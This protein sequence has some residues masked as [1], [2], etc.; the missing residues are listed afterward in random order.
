MSFYD[1]IQKYDW[2]QVEATI[3]NKTA[4]DVQRALAKSSCDLDDFMALISPAAAP[5]IE[6]MARKSSLL[7]QQRFGNTIQLYI[8]L[9]VSNACTNACVYCG[10]NHGNDIER[11][12]L[13]MEE[14]DQEVKRLKQFGFDHLLLVSG[15]DSRVCGVDY[16][17]QAIAQCKQDFAQLS[18]EVQPLTTEEYVT[19]QQAGLHAVYVYQ[20]TYRESTYKDYHPRGKKSNYKYRLETPDRIGQAGI[21]KIGLGVL[22]GL[23]DWR[24]DS[25]FTAL[26]LSYLEKHYWQSKYS[27]SFPRL[28]PFTGGFEPNSIV[29]HQELLQ[30]MCAYRLL[31]EHLEISLSTRESAFFRDHV[32][33]L[34]VTTMSAG[35]ST[36]PGGYTHP[37]ESLEQFSVNDERPPKVVAE[38]VAQQGYEVVWKDWEGYM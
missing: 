33:K 26:H 37:D 36:S 28:R 38:V 34:G 9:Y 2:D 10:F 21:H 19:L 12:V 7:T 4:V 14:L 22:L 1:V 24:T 31:N 29:G 11:K 32:M 5:Y 20:E 35:S 30:L 18:I 25:F 17:R 13:T 27:L 6:E 23:E 3:Y 15:E 8:P 16:F